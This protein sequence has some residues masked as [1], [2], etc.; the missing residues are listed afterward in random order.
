MQGDFSSAKETGKG[1]RNGIFF[2]HFF[3]HC[4]NKAAGMNL[5]VIMSKKKKKKSQVKICPFHHLTAPL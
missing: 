4:K 2:F 1:G 5:A 3:P